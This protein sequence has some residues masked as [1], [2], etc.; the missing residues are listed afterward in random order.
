L[1]RYLR[2]E[3]SDGD[4]TFSIH[5]VDKLLKGNGIT[6]YFEDK[7][8]DNLIKK[9]EQKGIEFTQLPKGQSWSWKE[10]HLLDFDGNSI[11][12][13]TAGENRKTPPW[14]I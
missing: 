12:L 6:I 14:R 8:V 5:L 2:L 3:V 1:P 7:N 9:L 13:F 11:I 10:A 4:A